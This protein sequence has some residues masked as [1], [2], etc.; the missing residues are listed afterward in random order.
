MFGPVVSVQQQKFKQSW[1]TTQ[2][3]EEPRCLCSV[4]FVVFWGFFKFYIVYFWKQVVAGEKVLRK[5]IYKQII[6]DK[7][8]FRMKKYVLE[9]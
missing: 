9:L 5:G 3:T 6:V 1:A 4:S 8:T 7:N 2:Q